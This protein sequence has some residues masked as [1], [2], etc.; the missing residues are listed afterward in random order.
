MGCLAVAP[1]PPCNASWG[2]DGYHQKE[3]AMN[4]YRSMIAAHTQLKPNFSLAVSGWTLGPG[5]ETFPK[6]DAGW[7]NDQLPPEVAIGA[8]NIECGHAPPDPGKSS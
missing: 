1:R 3:C 7:L 4:D 2:N 5:P 8:M 6:G